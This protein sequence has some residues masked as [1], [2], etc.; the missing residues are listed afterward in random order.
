MR[1]VKT[2]NIVINPF[3]HPFIEGFGYDD[4]DGDSEFALT[5]D[6]RLIFIY[7]HAGSYIEANDVDKEGL[8]LIQFNDGSCMEW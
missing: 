4:Y 1:N 5:N 7:M 6:G 8:F 2:G 3:H